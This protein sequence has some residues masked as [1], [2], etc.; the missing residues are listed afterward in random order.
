MFKLKHIEI[1]VYESEKYNLITVANAAATSCG[2]D[3]FLQQ[4]LAAWIMCTAEAQKN[5]R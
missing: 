1:T 5:L 4:L 2:E 3:A